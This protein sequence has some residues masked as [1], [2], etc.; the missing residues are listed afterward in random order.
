MNTQSVY[1]TIDDVVFHLKNNIKTKIGVSKINGV[2]VFAIKPILTGESVFTAWKYDTGIYAI[3]DEKLAEI[4]NYVLEL[5]DMYF[6][7]EKCGYKIIRLYNGLNFLFNPFSFC[8]SAY[9][10]KTNQ[11]IDNLGIAI[12]D[13]NVGDEVLEWY[14]ENIYI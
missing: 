9:P 12:K 7:N 2:G 1:A 14:V 3:P 4:P 6:I 8:N 11:N 13:I 5:M 10:N